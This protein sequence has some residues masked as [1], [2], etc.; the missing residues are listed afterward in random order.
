MTDSMHAAILRYLDEVA[1]SGSIRRAAERLNVAASA[2]S[3]Q[4]LKLEQSVGTDL[5]ERIPGGLR[6]TP[7]GE[8]MLR[9]VRSTLAEYERTRAD[10]DTLQGVRSGH[11]RIASLDSVMARLLPG[12]LTAFMAENPMVTFSITACGPGEIAKQV[13]DAKADIG[14]SFEMG[15]PAGVHVTHDIASPLCAMVAPDHPLAQ[16]SATTFAECARYP[17]L[18][19]EDR[20]PIRSVLETE[21]AEARLLARSVV[22]ANN[23]PVVRALVIAGVGIAFYTRLGFLDD[24][25]KGTVV[26]VPLSEQ[27]MRNLR[28]VLLLPRDRRPTAAVSAF[29]NE[30]SVRLDNIVLR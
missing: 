16:Q 28:L 3:R 7:A 14:I 15:N 25:A 26:A 19:Q 2:I 12:A 20:G 17:L 6:L 13:K 21:L 30:L 29:V 18:A 22:S 27:R 24:L 8:A 5:F 11:V 10:I 9:H 23:L 4:I 1:R